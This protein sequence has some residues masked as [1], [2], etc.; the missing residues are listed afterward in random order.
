MAYMSQEKKKA[1]SPAIKAVLKKYHMTGSIAVRN[2]STL[3]V[4]LKSGE[5]NIIKNHNDAAVANSRQ[6]KVYLA[7]TYIQVN[8]FHIDRTYTGKVA[9]FFTELIAAMQTGNHD[10][11]DSQ[12]DYFDV[13]WYIDINVG[14]W[15]QPY[16][17][18]I[19]R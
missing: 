4:N 14:Q 1:L 7:D 13:G 15:N 18:E 11:S 17:Y 9:K 3:V 6:E 5:L 12:T 2:H 8:Q 16:V 19:K 10:N